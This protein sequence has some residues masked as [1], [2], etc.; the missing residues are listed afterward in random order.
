MYLEEGC[1][2]DTVTPFHPGGKVD[3]R[4]LEQNVKFTSQAVTGI[5][6]VGM[7]GE[8]PTLSGAQHKE[9]LKRGT[10]YTREAKGKEIVVIGGTGSNALRE[11]IEY[12]KAA[13]EAGCDGVTLID[14]YYS[15]PPSVQLK[16]N[17]YEAISKKFPLLKIIPC[18][19]PSRTGTSL[20]PEDLRDIDSGN[21]CGVL[22]EVKDSFNDL[23][24][25]R[26]VCRPD[27][28]IFS[29][30]DEKTLKIVSDREINGRGVFSVVAN[31]APFAV[32]RLLYYVKKG[33]IKKARLI[34]RALKPLYEIMTIKEPRFFDGKIIV[35]Y[36]PVPITVKTAMNI[37]GLPAGICRFPLGNMPASAVNQIT[38]ALKKVWI[39]SPWVLE[40]IEDFYNV[41]IEERLY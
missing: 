17:Y 14:P 19:F 2:V 30:Q 29:I 7:A 6:L 23:R 27:F 10:A 16:E 41:K 33:E 39:E 4:G 5:C 12:T 9:V 25:I 18:S 21:I 8:S 36:Y 3:Y 11:A 13:K 38:E 1:Y 24:E 31:I 35:D 26:K 28:A 34:D 15:R 20:S 22:R 37:L 40:P 32:Q